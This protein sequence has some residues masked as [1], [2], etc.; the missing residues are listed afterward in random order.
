[1]SDKLPIYRVEKDTFGL[2]GGWKV[3]SH[4]SASQGWT[5]MTELDAST[6]SRIA[7]ALVEGGWTVVYSEERLEA[8]FKR[9]HDLAY[10]EMEAQYNAEHPESPI[11]LSY[12][13][14]QS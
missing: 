2:R 9:R 8:E 14:M 12:E 5:C 10:A 4:H 13:A 1:M 11:N 3:V 7:I 6:A